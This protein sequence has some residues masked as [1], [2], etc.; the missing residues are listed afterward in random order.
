MESSFPNNMASAVSDALLP[1]SSNEDDDSS[2]QSHHAN[3]TVQ[4][5]NDDPP[6]DP[7]VLYGC[8]H[9][10]DVTYNKLNHYKPNLLAANS[11]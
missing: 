3:D 11:M 4:E 5:N 2:K 6:P 1:S 7:L 8:P 9:S 10:T